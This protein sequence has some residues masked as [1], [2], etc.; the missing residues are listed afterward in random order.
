MAGRGSSEMHR[1]RRADMQPLDIKPYNTMTR[2]KQ[3]LVPLEPGKVRTYVCGM[4][5]Y[6]YCHMG[7]ARVMVASD[8]VTRYLRWRGLDVISVRNITD[9]ADQLLWRPEANAA[10]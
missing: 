4:T 2:R 5:V 3:P 8:V 6:D 7:H 10:C 1:G 9:I